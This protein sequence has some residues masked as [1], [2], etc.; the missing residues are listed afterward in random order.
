MPLSAR[1]NFRVIARENFPDEETAVDVSRCR[2]CA[3]GQKNQPDCAHSSSVRRPRP[4]LYDDHPHWA[5][6]CQVYDTALWRIRLWR[7]IFLRL[8]AVRVITDV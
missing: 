2:T 5:R 7:V 3:G 6:L 8:R 4:S 1:T